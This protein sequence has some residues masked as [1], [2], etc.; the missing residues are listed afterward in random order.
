MSACESIVPGD[1]RPQYVPHQNTAYGGGLDLPFLGRDN[2]RNRRDDGRRF[3]YDGKCHTLFL[4]TTCVLQ[5]RNRGSD[6][7][8]PA[9]AIRASASWG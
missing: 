9:G 1:R 6:F 5:M 7:G 2:P 4:L 3:S 8:F